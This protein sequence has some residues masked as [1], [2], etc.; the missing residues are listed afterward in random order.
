MSPHGNTVKCPGPVAPSTVTLITAAFAPMGMVPRPAIGTSIIVPPA[1]GPVAVKRC[2]G[3]HP[4]LTSVD[5]PDR[6]S[7][8]DQL[9][10][11]RPLVLIVGHVAFLGERQ[12]REV[13]I[14]RRQRF[15]GHR[16]VAELERSAS[17]EHSV[18]TLPVSENV[19][20]A[21]VDS[22]I[23]SGTV[24]RSIESRRRG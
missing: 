6:V 22:V 23:L 18:L 10:E 7:R 3:R 19:N 5:Q 20:S 14:A 13:V 2:V 16:A 9:P 4:R 1:T 24:S 15:V 21:S 11:D 12:D 17:S 8:R